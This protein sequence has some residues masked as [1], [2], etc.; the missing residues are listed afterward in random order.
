MCEKNKGKNKCTMWKCSKN[1]E[2]N[3]VNKFFKWNKLYWLVT[4]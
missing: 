3:G 2:G 4:I 1:L